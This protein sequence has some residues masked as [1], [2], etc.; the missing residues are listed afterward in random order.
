M[1]LRRCAVFPYENTI[2]AWCSIQKNVPTGTPFL[3]YFR[4]ETLA[5]SWFPRSQDYFAFLAAAQEATE[6]HIVRDF[7]GGVQKTRCLAAAQEAT[8]EH[9][10]RIFDHEA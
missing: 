7:G 1:G 4:S 5:S 3:V 6:E 9:I 10:E 8:E 2:L